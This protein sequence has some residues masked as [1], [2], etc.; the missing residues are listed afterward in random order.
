MIIPLLLGAGLV[1]FLL[2]N[3]KDNDSIPPELV[4]F[5][6]EPIPYENPTDYVIR[7]VNEVRRLAGVAP[8][9]LKILS[10][11]KCIFD[12]CSDYKS[13]GIPHRLFGACGE[14]GQNQCVFYSLGSADI[15]KC[16]D[17]MHAEGPGLDFEKHGH[18][19]NMIN[20]DYTQVTAAY[21]A[22]VL[23]INFY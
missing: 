17:T 8:L 7:Y 19:L 14:I 23:T 6:L 2:L 4:K 1:T 5:E 20:P 16:L 11:G 18:Y 15:S 12:Q 10:N 22:T 21:Y 3:K 9:T 13:S